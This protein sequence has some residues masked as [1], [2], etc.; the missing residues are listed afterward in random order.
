MPQHQQLSFL[1]DHAELL[2]QYAAKAMQEKKGLFEEAQG[3]LIELQKYQEEY[4]SRLG[5]S[6]RNGL[7]AKAWRDFYLFLEKLEEAIQ[8]QIQLVERYRIS[9]D[10]AV[11][12]WNH[13]RQKHQ[14]Y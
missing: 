6:D 3:K 14:S 7:S 9:Y 4:R 11:G 12:D 1:I 8:M 5:Q 13:T 10:I 2:E